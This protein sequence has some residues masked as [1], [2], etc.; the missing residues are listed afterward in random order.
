MGAIPFSGCSCLALLALAGF[1]VFRRSTM[2]CGQCSRI[3]ALLFLISRLIAF[4]GQSIKSANS[5]RGVV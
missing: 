4:V 5:S 1:G 3:R 2:C